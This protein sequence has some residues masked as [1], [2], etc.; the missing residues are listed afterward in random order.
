MV[1]V[2]LSALDVVVVSVEDLWG[3]QMNIVAGIVA[4]LGCPKVLVRV[5][6]ELDRPV[7]VNLMVNPVKL[8]KVP[9][10]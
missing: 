8:F 3:T 4:V 5:T 2:E 1:V 10:L 9:S 7:R 6:M